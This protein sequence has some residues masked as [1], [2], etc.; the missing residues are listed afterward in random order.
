MRE[1]LDRLVGPELAQQ[2]MNGTLK[3]GDLPPRPRSLPALSKSHR[4]SMPRT[5]MPRTVHAPNLNARSTYPGRNSQGGG[6]RKSQP[7]GNNLD[8]WRAG[9]TEHYRSIMPIARVGAPQGAAGPQMPHPGLLLPAPFISSQGFFGPV[10]NHTGTPQHLKAIAA[11]VPGTCARFMTH[12]IAACPSST[13]SNF[14]STS[15]TAGCVPDGL[16]ITSEYG[17]RF[18]VPPPGSLRSSNYYSTTLWRGSLAMRS[19]SGKIF[20]EKDH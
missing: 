20:G 15:V 2:A 10:P 7:M 11:A 8:M 14:R 17:G 12:D 18:R 13:V 3:R 16:P 1:A 19:G 4:R 5:T 9:P 6:H